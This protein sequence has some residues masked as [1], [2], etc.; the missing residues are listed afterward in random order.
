MSK[1]VRIP[2]LPQKEN[3]QQV[4]KALLVRFQTMFSVKYME[5]WLNGSQYRLVTPCGTGSNPVI[6]AK[7]WV[8]LLVGR[9]GVPFKHPTPVR[10]RNP[11][12]NFEG[13]DSVAQLVE[14][15][16]FNVGVAGFESRPSH[17]T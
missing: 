8:N 14:H 17:E 11:V 1:W 15:D 6:S 7:C 16:T 3:V 9:G 4:K 2:P 10:I 12:Q 13:F 5:V